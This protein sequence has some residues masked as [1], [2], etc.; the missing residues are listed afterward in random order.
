MFLIGRW[1]FTGRLGGVRSR[2]EPA[3]LMAARF[4]QGAGGAM[5]G[6]VVLG[7][8]VAISR[9]GGAGEGDRRLQLRRVAGASIGLLAGGALTQAISWH[10][11]FFVNVPI[12]VAT[13]MV[14][15][16]T[17]RT[18]GSV[19]PTAPTCSARCS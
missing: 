14:A 6:A 19:W 3:V 4:L 5:T 1:V 17:S 8:I 2:G 12:G 15:W 9:A 10:W 11:I 16:A 18:K 7:M 13:A